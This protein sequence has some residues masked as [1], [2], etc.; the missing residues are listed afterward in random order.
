L[1]KVVLTVT[2]NGTPVSAVAGAL[3]E[4]ELTLT[5]AVERTLVVELLLLLL[6]PPVGSETCSWSTVAEAETEKS[7]ADGFV[8]VTDQLVGTAGIKVAAE[9]ASTVFSTT[10]GFVPVIVQSGGPLRVRVVSTLVG[11]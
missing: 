1:C 11:P 7:C 4:T 8:Q 3:T 9:V 10:T 6:L 5:S 2:L